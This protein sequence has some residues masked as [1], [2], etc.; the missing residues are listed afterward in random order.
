M[1]L[2]S[3]PTQA[4]LVAKYMCDMISSMDDRGCT[5]FVPRFETKFESNHKKR[6]NFWNLKSSYWSCH[7]DRVPQVYE[8][9]PWTYHQDY[10][11]DTKM[12]ARIN[13]IHDRK[14]VQFMSSAIPE[15]DKP[16]TK[17]VNGIEG[18]LHL[19]KFPLHI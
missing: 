17:N 8:A 16:S 18:L 12:L 14:Y 1:K 2:V 13:D 3:V 11:A 10:R 15:A 5:T 6:K 4:E 19:F 7:A 9:A